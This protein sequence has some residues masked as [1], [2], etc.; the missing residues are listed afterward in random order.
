M[1]N[2]KLILLPALSLVVASCAQE[3]TPINK[4]IRS[5]DVPVNSSKSSVDGG[6][7]INKSSS[8]TDEEIADAYFSSDS[9]KSTIIDPITV[10]DINGA[11]ELRN[12]SDL[13]HRI[14]YNEYTSPSFITFKKKMKLFAN[15][16]S[17]IILHRFFVSDK[18]YVLSPLSIEMCL[19]LAIR[20]AEGETRDEI[21]AAFDM[22][23][24]TFNANYKL[25]FN[26]LF[27]NRKNSNDDIIC[28]LLL[29]NSL[30]V[31]DDLELKSSCL[32][33]LRDD[34]YCYSY[35]VDFDGD[36]NNANRAIGD[37]IDHSTNGLL[38]PSIDLSPDTLFMLMNTLY[39]KSI[40]NEDGDDLPYAPVDYKFT[41][42]DGSESKKRL[43]DGYYVRGKPI[44]TD[45]YSCF[46]TTLYGYSLY[47]VKPNEGK[48]LK[49]IFTEDA[50]NYVLD[51]NNI[52]TQD[53]VKMEKY[54]TQCYFP[55]F[56]ADGDFD[57]KDVLQEDLGIQSLFSIAACDMSGLTD[58]E[59]FCEG[60]R[61]LATLDV[62]KKGIEGAAVTYMW[63]AGATAPQPDPYTY[64]NYTF[65]VD[66]E[67]GFIMMSG[68][69]VVFSGV[70]NN[71]DK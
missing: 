46:Y 57:I 12:P 11:E 33:A 1:K 25:Y 19:G 54:S 2:K 27:E 15:K 28:Q 66:K 30:W 14:T 16:L 7:S 68:G 69:G 55:E 26:Y 61:H 10:K 50:M 45:D 62:N 20:C 37:F 47:F 71:I 60:I 36:N 39:A 42:S 49:D 9:I 51:E 59:V 38:K 34:Y 29:T 22:D 48:N 43:L 24:D 63:S 70:V 18:N 31:D 67:F 58:E 44:V 21:L 53:D 23:Y 17:E 56:N 3:P 40:W 65:V 5:S 4:S 41:N 52:I 32:D 13:S 8:V 64:L 6:D 35:A